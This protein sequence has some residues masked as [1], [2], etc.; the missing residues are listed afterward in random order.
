MSLCFFPLAGIPVDDA[1]T[2]IKLLKW[3]DEN[4]IKIY[5]TSQQ[6]LPMG[7][8]DIIN[9]NQRRQLIAVSVFYGGMEENKFKDLFGE[10]Y[11][12]KKLEF[13]S[14]FVT[15]IIAEKLKEM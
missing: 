6:V 10:D 13:V 14:D 15:K 8:G 12:F 2:T 4:G 1:E 11:N 3:C 9:P 7:K 5:H